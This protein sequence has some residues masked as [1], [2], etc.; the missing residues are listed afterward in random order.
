MDCE[1]ALQI[2]PANSKVLY[3]KSRARFG[4]GD[5]HQALSAARNAKRIT[6]KSQEINSWESWLRSLE[7]EREAS[8]A[9]E[10]CM[11]RAFNRSDGGSN[12]T[13][14]ADRACLE[15]ATCYLR[16]IG[17]TS[18]HTNATTFGTGTRADWKCGPRDAAEGSL[19]AACH[20]F[21]VELQKRKSESKSQDEYQ[22]QVRFLLYFCALIIFIE[23]SCAS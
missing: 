18:T 19:Y 12:E 3:R 10:A 11:E 22:S 14:V 16:V 21:V 8:K 2:D 15:A 6:P 17:G 4:L 13:D 1:C 7:L 23:C 9:A 20:A 5:I